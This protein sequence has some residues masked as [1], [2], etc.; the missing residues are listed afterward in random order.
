MTAHSNAESAV[1]AVVTSGWA[2]RLG[3]RTASRVDW[4][5]QAKRMV[6]PPPGLETRAETAGEPQRAGSLRAASQRSARAGGKLR[7][8]R[9]RGVGGAY[10]NGHGRERAEPGCVARP[11]SFRCGRAI[12]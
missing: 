10:W 11:L 5:E 4:S 9:E 3:A 7:A 6:Q 2:R 12:R 8:N 1:S